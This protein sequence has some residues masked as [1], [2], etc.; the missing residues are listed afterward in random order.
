MTIYITY[1]FHDFRLESITSSSHY[2]KM[3]YLVKEVR[4]I[5]FRCVV[6]IFIYNSFGITEYTKISISMSYY[7]V[8]ELLLLANISI[9]KLFKIEFEEKNKIK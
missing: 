3:F 7:S 2:I 6:V 9:F 5:S 4:I 1:K 8:L